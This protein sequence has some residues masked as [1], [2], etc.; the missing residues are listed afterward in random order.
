MQIASANSETSSGQA[1]LVVAAVSLISFLLIGSTLASLGVY[2]PVYQDH[3]NWSEQDVGGIAAILLVGLSLA[4]LLSG[5]LLNKVGPRNVVIAGIIAV[6]GG[7]LLA[8]RAQDLTQMIIAI[9]LT[10]AGVGM[11]TIV[12]GATVINMWFRENRGIPMAVFI[13]SLVLSSA[14]IPPVT[15]LLI[16]SGGWRDAMKTT[17][18]VIAVLGLCLAAFV[19]APSVD[20]QWESSVGVIDGNVAG[21]TVKEA[22][23]SSRFW[24]LIAAL[25]LVQLSINGIMYNVVSYL[26]GQDFSSAKAV[27]IYSFANLCGLPGLF[28]CG[29]L[30]DRYG[31]RRV[32]PVAAL[33]LAGGTFTLIA[34]TGQ[35]EAG[36]LALVGFVVMW[37]LGSSIPSQ[38]GPIIL[39]ELVGMRSF[40]TLMGIKGALVSLVG[41]S[42]PIL[43]GVL[44]ATHQSYSLPFIVCG[45]LALL[46]IPLFLL[47]TRKQKISNNPQVLRSNYDQ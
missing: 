39:A 12:P 46:A 15:D 40:S 36:L 29:F 17:A 25:T 1:W 26:I 33:I 3:F 13:A 41:A 4:G 27:S 47:A 34:V 28:I 20:F 32:I 43:V 6:I 37:G 5:W 10:G 23:K 18:L 11:A 35:A 19:R 7:C 44:F 45:I 14:L 16:Q 9:G 31:A 24:F 21:M 38:I 42:A 30:A 22:F 8:A 2:L